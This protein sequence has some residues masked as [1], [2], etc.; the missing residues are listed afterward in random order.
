MAIPGV[1]AYSDPVLRY[2]VRARAFI[3]SG[4][5]AK[6]LPGASTGDPWDTKHLNRLEQAFLTT[7]GDED[8]DMMSEDLRAGYEMFLGEGLVRLFGGEWVFLPAEMLGGE[9]ATPGLGVQYPGAEHLDVVT[10]MLPLAL[11]FRT[12]RWW[13]SAFITTSELLG[14]SGSQ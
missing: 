1:D 12:G 13:S 14:R 7:V 11:K 6:L 8:T 10:S 9:G 2:R 5:F 3:D 4:E